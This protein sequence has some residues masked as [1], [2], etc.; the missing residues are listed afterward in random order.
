MVFGCVGR[1]TRNGIPTKPLNRIFLG[2]V[3]ALVPL[4]LQN[5]FEN[6]PPMLLSDLHLLRIPKH[7]P[8]NCHA[9][10]VNR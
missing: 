3:V 10:L 2:P 8:G 9:V 5:R 6:D 7:A 1:P 4:R